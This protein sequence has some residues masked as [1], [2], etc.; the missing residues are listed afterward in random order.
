MNVAPV[1]SKSNP[2]FSW[3]YSRLKNFET[4]ARRYAEVELK[5]SRQQQRSQE[6]DRGDALHEA[7]YSR[8]SSG[9]V[10]PPEFIYMEHPAQQLCKVLHPFQIIQCE[11]KLSFDKHY[12]PTGFFDK[13]TWFRTKIDYFRHMPSIKHPEWRIGHI[14]DYKTGKPREDYTQLALNAFAIFAHF[15]DV[16]SVR[17]EFMWTEYNDTSHENFHRSQMDEIMAGLLPR[18]TLLRDAMAS[19]VFAPRP[20]GLCYEYC[21]VESCEYYGKRHARAN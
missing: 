12:K 8:V 14:V 3:S 17:A 9:T 15:Q 19:N 7:M 4:C 10:L 20:C 18:V 13:N 6:L 16:Q 2:Q 11:L 21:P 5:K 1:T